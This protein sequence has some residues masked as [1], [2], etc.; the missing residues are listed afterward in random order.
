M[1]I[2][3]PFYLIVKGSLKNKKVNLYLF[4]WDI[5]IKHFFGMHFECFCDFKYLA[6]PSIN[7]STFHS[8]DLTQF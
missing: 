5:K 3:V 4:G 8:T 2:R 7:Y 6:Q 1:L